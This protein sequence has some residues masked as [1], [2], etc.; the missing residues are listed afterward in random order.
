MG[1]DVLE[2]VEATQIAGAIE[3]GKFGERSVVDWRR[4]SSLTP[5]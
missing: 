3:Q 2:K 4:K 1:L 5:F